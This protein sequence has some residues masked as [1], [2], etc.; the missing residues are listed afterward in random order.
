MHVNCINVIDLAFSLNNVG[1]YKQKY[2]K[3]RINKYTKTDEQLVYIIIR[4]LQD[5]YKIFYQRHV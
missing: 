3:T 5:Q 4:K 2:N 1:A